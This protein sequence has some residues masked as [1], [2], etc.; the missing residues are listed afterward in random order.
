MIDLLSACVMMRNK[1]IDGRGLYHPIY[2]CLPDPCIANVYTNIIRSHLAH[3][4]SIRQDVRTFNAM[5]LVPKN[6]S[7]MRYLFNG[8]LSLSVHDLETSALLRCC[9]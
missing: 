8:L 9:Q 3:V 4:K 6:V 2:N 7:A 5:R 1:M